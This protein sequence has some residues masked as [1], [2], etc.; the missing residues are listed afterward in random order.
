MISSS[1]YNNTEID[2]PW[3]LEYQSFTIAKMIQEVV[4]ATK[5]NHETREGIVKMFHMKRFCKA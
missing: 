3:C 4:V 2:L 1:I 5:I